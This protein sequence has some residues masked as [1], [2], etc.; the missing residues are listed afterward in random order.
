MGHTFRYL[1]SKP[2]SVQVHTNE[3]VES[4]P[5]MG[6]LCC[7]VCGLLLAHMLPKKSRAVR[8]IAAYGLDLES[9][10]VVKKMP[11]CENRFFSVANT[12][13]ESI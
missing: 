5:C 4:R 9:L 3:G 10:A 7:T 6:L 2:T 11:P 1:E 12:V 13:Y 8:P